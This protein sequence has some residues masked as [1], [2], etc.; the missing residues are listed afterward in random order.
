MTS[1]SIA[2]MLA[3]LKA[4]VATS[5]QLVH[6]AL[7]KAGRCAAELNAFAAIDENAMTLAAES[8]QRYANGLARELEGIQSS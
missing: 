3:G 1:P 2:E 7:E 5:R 4:G 6:G 8:D